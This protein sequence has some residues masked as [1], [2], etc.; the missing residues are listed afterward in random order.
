MSSIDRFWSKVNKTDSC[1][2]WTATLYDSGYGRFRYNNK[3]NKA[4][5]IAY[6]FLVG[7]IPEGLELDHL[8]RVRCCVNP[9]HLEPVTHRENMVRG[10]NTLNKKS[11]LP[12]G[13]EKCWSRYRARKRFNGVNIHIGTFDTPEDASIAYET[14]VM[15]DSNHWTTK[16]EG[17]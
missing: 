7:E 13:V 2:I 8:C 1:W 10:A 6:N 5:R 12:V 4:H 3:W 17:L 9:D 15:V 11:T 14:A 16:Y